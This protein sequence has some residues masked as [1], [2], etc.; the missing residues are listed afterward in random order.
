MNFHSIYPAL[1]LKNH[2]NKVFRFNI[3]SH[4]YREL[5]AKYLIS[6]KKSPPTQGKSL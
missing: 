6:Y 3:S 1:I 4:I 5:F 2:D